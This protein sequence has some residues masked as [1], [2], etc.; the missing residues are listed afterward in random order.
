MAYG[1]QK[2]V[3]STRLDNVGNGIN[4][5]DNKSPIIGTNKFLIHVGD[6]TLEWIKHEGTLLTFK[7][8]KT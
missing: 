8:T 2:M 4:Y 7:I 6:Y 1:R 5:F 3:D